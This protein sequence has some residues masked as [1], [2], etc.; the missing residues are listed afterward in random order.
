[1]I[2]VPSLG[3][4]TATEFTD[5]RPFSLQIDYTTSR[6]TAKQR[7]LG[8]TQDFNLLQIVVFHF[9]N[10]R[11]IQVHVIDMHCRAR[12]RTRRN[13]SVA[14]PANLKVVTSKIGLAVRHVGHIELQIG[15]RVDLIS[16]NR[17]SIKGAHR[18]RNR[19]QRFFAALRAHDDFFD[20][21]AFLCHRDRTLMRKYPQC[22]QHNR[23][24]RL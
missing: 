24:R 2:I 11:G 21:V 13:Q 17:I 10:A 15:K 16:I 19:L 3:F 6:V 14:N 9:K 18:N 23:P 20:S 5:Y 7:P 12:I 8:P 1:M 4:N 22:R